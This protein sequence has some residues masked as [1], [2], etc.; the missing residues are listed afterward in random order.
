MSQDLNLKG[1]YTIDGKSGSGKSTAANGLAK[2][3]KI[4]YLSSGRL[5]RIAA[6][7]LIENKPRNIIAFLNKYFSNLNYNKLKK[8]NL[9]TQEIS[10]FSA[11]IA[12]Q[13]KIRL[14]IRK[15]Q[16]TWASNHKNHC[17]IEG[18]DS[19]QIF[20]NARIKFYIK[21][22]FNIA[23]RRRYLQLR[24]KNSEITLQQVKTQQKTRDYS[25]TTRKHNRLILAPDHVVIRSD[26]NSRKRIIDLMIEKIKKCK[27]KKWN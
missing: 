1:L 20:K 13:K 19:H 24:K 11:I 27:N 21:C 23:V 3:L 7:K 10:N 8:I 26:I 25:D 17:I 4:P 15:Y 14:T 12:R 5:Y 9:H 2:R 6:K 16:T 18:R 22:N